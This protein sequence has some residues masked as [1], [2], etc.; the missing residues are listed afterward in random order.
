MSTGSVSTGVVAAIPRIHLA[1][2]QITA[3]RVVI[4]LVVLG[5]VGLLVALVLGRMLPARAGRATGPAE[6][7]PAGSLQP[8]ADLVKALQK[9]D[10]ATQGEVGF[11]LRAAPV[12]ALAASAVVAALVPAGPRAAVVDT[13]AGTLVVVAALVIAGTAASLAKAIQAPA[14]GADGALR[15]GEQ[16][17]AAMPVLLVALLSVTAQAGSLSLQT[18]VVA[19]GQGVIGGVGVIGL[20]FVIPQIL[21]AVAFFVAQQGLRGRAPFDLPHRSLGGGAPGGPSL[22]GVR[23][24]LLAGAEVAAEVAMAGVAATMFFGGWALPGVGVNEPVMDVA[25]PIVLAV[26][27]VSL[28]VV[29]R[30]LEV[31]LP[32]VSTARFVALAQRVLLPMAVAGLCFTVVVRG[33]W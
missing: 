12:T 4:L 21:G 32:R 2:W 8:V 13:S 20:P 27:V 25:G 31:V 23:F 33:L 1:Y 22:T 28:L 30:W 6:V 10:G 24:L 26:K 16:V 29:G 18:I 17:L 7:G 11:V 3:L 5:V 14:R 15:A 19:Q 9:Q